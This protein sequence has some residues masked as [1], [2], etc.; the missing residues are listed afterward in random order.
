LKILIIFQIFWSPNGKKTAS[1]QFKRSNSYSND[2]ISIQMDQSRAA[3]SLLPINPNSRRY[4]G[5]YCQV[6]LPG[7]APAQRYRSARAGTSPAAR[8]H[9]HILEGGAIVSSGQAL[10]STT[11]I[12]LRVGSVSG[13]PSLSTLTNFF[14][15]SMHH[16]RS[17][18]KIPFCYREAS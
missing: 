15:H 18:S 16:R 11:G 5:W 1:F 9:C 14:H 10:P 3:M 4:C 8:S 17:R 7:P 6:L 12:S 2:Q 13:W